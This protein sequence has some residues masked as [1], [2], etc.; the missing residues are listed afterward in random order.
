MG[1]AARAL[2]KQALEDEWRSSTFWLFV[3]IRLAGFGIPIMAA[4]NNG[5]GLRLAS[6]VAVPFALFIVGTVATGVAVLAA[7]TT[8]LFRSV[9]PLGFWLGGLLVAFCVLSV[10]LAAM[11]NGFGTAIFLVLFG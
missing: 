7:G 11:R 5:L 2:H 1:L 4:L 6:P 3:L 9:A 10:T 8:K